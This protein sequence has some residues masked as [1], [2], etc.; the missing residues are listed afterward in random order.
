MEQRGDNIQASARGGRWCGG[1][2]R[3]LLSDDDSR[4]ELADL[5]FKSL[6]LEPDLR[7]V[8]LAQKE[9]RARLEQHSASILG[10]T[11]HG[12]RCDEAQQW[13]HDKAEH[14]DHFGASS[15]GSTTRI[16]HLP[17]M[18]RRVKA[19]DVRPK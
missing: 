7:Q 15:A 17:R 4:I 18:H 1:R 13:S 11:A 2:G 5:L 3:L 10:H 14:P 8:N 12:A 19:A 16:P 9:E 6:T